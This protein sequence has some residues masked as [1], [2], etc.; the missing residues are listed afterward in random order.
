MHVQPVRSNPVKY[1]GVEE[2]HRGHRG[3]GPRRVARHTDELTFAAEAQHLLVH[4]RANDILPLLRCRHVARDCNLL[5]ALRVAIEYFG[6]EHQLLGSLHLARRLRP[7]GTAVVLCN[8]F[9]EEASRSHRIYR[10]LATQLERAGFSVLRFDYTG[11]G[12]SQGETLTVESAIKDIG[13]A[14]EHLRATSGVTNISL[15]G[16]RFGATL[17]MLAGARRQPRPYHLLMWDPVVDGRAYLRELG[18]QHQAYM[19]E[20]LG[21]GWRDRLRVRADGSPHETLGVSISDTLANQLSAIDL[22]KVT[23]GADHHTVLTTRGSD[24]RT[25]L[26]EDARWIELTHSA[27]WN[28]DAALNAMTVPMDIVQALVARIEESV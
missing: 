18:T 15:V 2:H 14:A 17:A 19:R 8:P 21:P 23:S 9:G 11:T 20:E 12:D 6:S 25:W 16:L 1:A 24:A 13:I 22:T 3:R 4:R 26:P 27:A 5:P 28:S 10:V 7:R